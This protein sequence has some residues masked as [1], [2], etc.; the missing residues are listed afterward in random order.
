MKQAIL[1]S[2]LLLVGCGHIGTSY[3]GNEQGNLTV[4]LKGSNDNMIVAGNLRC[5]MSTGEFMTVNITKP[6]YVKVSTFGK[7]SPGKID[8]KPGDYIRIEARD[9]LFNINYVMTKIPPAIAKNELLGL[10]KASCLR[11]S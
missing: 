5:N 11:R 7:F 3:A 10:T 8:V 2:V 9:N 4:Y 6:D 1:L